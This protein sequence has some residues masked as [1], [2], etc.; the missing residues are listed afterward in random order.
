[1]TRRILT[2]TI[3]IPL[4]LASLFLFPLPAFLLL[5]D[6]ILLLALHEFSR[7]GSAY[8]ARFYY[9]SYLLALL[10][11]WL[12]VYRS[13]L[14]VSFVLIAVLTTLVWSVVSKRPLKYSFPDVA[15]NL[16]GLCYLAVP[17]ALIATF[18]PGSHGP[19]GPYELVLVLGIVWVSDAAAFFIGRAI[20]SRRITPTISPNKTLEGY[21]AALLLPLLAAAAVG[22]YLVPGRSTG[23]LASVTL[24][25]SVAGVVGDLFESALKRG[26]DIKDTSHL[27]PGHGGVLD[28]IDSLLFAVPAYYLFKIL[29]EVLA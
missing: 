5:L 28:R 14:T 26:A 29:S 7:L 4:V 2:A 27:V 10:A 9:V 1:M 3:L 15:G 25:V 24:I 18:H 11:P 20:G 6:A 12:F 17:F 22:G 13:E 23:Y 19:S 8:G 21:F 16:L